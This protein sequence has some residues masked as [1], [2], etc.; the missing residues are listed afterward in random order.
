MV[1]NREAILSANDSKMETIPVPE[2][3][4]E[5]FIKT[6]SAGERDRWELAVQGKKIEDIRS[7]LLVQC[8]CDDNGGLLFS[9][10]DIGELSRKASAPIQRLFNAAVKLNRVS[11]EDIEELEKN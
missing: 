6:I 11:G 9:P 5:V 8:V 10:S 7:S 2:W 1:L 4:G 3:G